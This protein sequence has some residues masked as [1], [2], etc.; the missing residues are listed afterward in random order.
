MTHRRTDLF[1]LLGIAVAFTVS[2]IAFTPLHQGLSSDE[3]VYV[4]QISRHRPAMPWSAERARGMALLVAPVTLLTGSPTALRLYLTVLAGLGLFLALLAWRGLRPAWVLALAGVVFGGLWAAQAGAALVFPNFWAAIGGASGVGLF[5]RGVRR[6]V[7][8][9]YV[10]ILLTAA[11]ACT[12]LMRPADAVFLFVPLIIAAVAKKEWRSPAVLWAIISGLVLGLGEWLAETYMYFGGLFARLRAAS[13]AGGGTGFHPLNGLRVLNGSAGWSYP[14]TLAWWAVFLLLA[15]VGVWVAGRSKGWPFA[16]VPAVCALSVYVL[17][18]FPNLVSARYLLPA[19]ILLA[20]PVA[21]AIAWISVRAQGRLR[22]AG[23]TAAVIFV[24]AG[25]VSQ[26]IVLDRQWGIRQAEIATNGRVIS[27]LYHLKVRPP[28]VVTSDSAQRFAS[29]AIPAAYHL[30]CSYV[31]NMTQISL[32]S[33][34][35]IVMI[36]GSLGHPFSY[37]RGWPDRRLRTTDGTVQIW[38]EPEGLLV[39]RSSPAG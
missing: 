8:P 38:V 36:E 22:L 19:W 28:C 24:V 14:A 11:T 25:L 17:Y 39:R 34:R 26:H 30:Y 21:D 4:S 16:L 5:L 37:A 2:A 1:W 7:S 23:I 29:S 15:S 20:I 10:F 33:H 3:A 18:S 13:L 9:R 27:E 12:A 6:I 31:W 32:P 35:R